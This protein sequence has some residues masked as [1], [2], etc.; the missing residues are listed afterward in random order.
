[1]DGRTGTKVYIPASHMPE[2]STK[3]AD[4]SGHGL[5][6]FSYDSPWN[7]LFGG[8]GAQRDWE[9]LRR[10]PDWDVEYAIGGFAGCLGVRTVGPRVTWLGGGKGRWG[11]RIAYARAAQTYARTHPPSPNGIWSISPSVFAPVPALLAHPERTAIS[12][13]HLVG[14]N[15]LRKYGPVGAFALW[16]ENAI[17]KRGRHFLCINNAT[18]REVAARNP[19]ARVVVVPTGFQPLDAPP[20][21]PAEDFTILFF[22]RLDLYM[23][24]LDRLLDAFAKIAPDCPSARLVMAGRGGADVVADLSRRIDAHPA[25]GRISLESD[26]SSSRK[27]ELFAGACVF[28]APSRFEGWCIAAVEAASCGVPVVASTADGF[29]DSVQDGKT[30]ILVP[31]DDRSAA[32]DLSNAILG[33]FADP[34]S[35]RAMSSAG[36][37]WAEQFSWDSVAARHAEVFAEIADGRARG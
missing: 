31:N 36:R 9:I 37:I 34:A 14:R 10:L 22:G 33:L 12:L 1:M 35:R 4:A 30:G 29:L 24:G 26:V 19:L 15:A 17:V 8:G 13:F 16:H 21:S 20:T 25:R 28:C 23:K 32:E 2:N 27:A 5:L 7:P 3:T 11:S 6:H 18:A